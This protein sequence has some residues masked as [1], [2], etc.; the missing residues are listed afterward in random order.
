M[1]T[2]PKNPEAFGDLEKKQVH[3]QLSELYACHLFVHEIE[4]LRPIIY[5]HGK[6]LFVYSEFLH[7]L[8]NRFQITP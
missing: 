2:P 4:V 8:T 6:N 3:L 7:L 5:P 1:S